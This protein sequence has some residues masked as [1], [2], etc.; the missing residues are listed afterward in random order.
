MAVSQSG[1]RPLFILSRRSEKGRTKMCGTNEISVI[2]ITG[3]RVFSQVFPREEYRAGVGNDPRR[4]QP[5]PHA[6]TARCGA[7]RQASGASGPVMSM[8]EVK[9]GTPWSGNA[10]PPKARRSLCTPTGAFSPALLPH[11][12]AAAAAAGHIGARRVH[13]PRRR[14]AM[15]SRRR[16]HATLRGWTAAPPRHGP[17]AGRSGHPG[18]GAGRGR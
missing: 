7:E 13:R 2:V 16:D 5:A 15:R 10:K 18:V 1:M 9:G 3:A 4:R 14:G 6:T 11:G 17:A 8:S 12:P